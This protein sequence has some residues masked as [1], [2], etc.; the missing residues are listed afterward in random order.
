MIEDPEELAKFVMASYN[1]GLGHVVDARALTRKFNGDD[2]IWSDVSENLL[3]LS[4]SKY[5]KDPVVKLGYA[6]GSEPVNYVSQILERYERYKDL[7][8]G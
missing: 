3:K 4:K 6:R 5:F 7:V 1:V 2:Q 8:P